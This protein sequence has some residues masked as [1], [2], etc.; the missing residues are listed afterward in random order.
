MRRQIA[1]VPF[2]VVDCAEP[3]TDIEVKIL[4]DRLGCGLDQWDRH[5]LDH[6]LTIA[7]VLQVSP[8]F[9]RKADDIR[10]RLVREIAAGGER[11]AIALDLDL[12]DDL[13]GYRKDVARMAVLREPL[14]DRPTASAVMRAAADLQRQMSDLADV[15]ERS[16]RYMAEV[17]AEDDAGVGRIVDPIRR[18]FLGELLDIAAEADASLILPSNADRE[19]DTPL[20]EFAEEMVALAEDRAR[21]MAAEDELWAPAHARVLRWQKAAR[22]TL[23]SDLRLICR[24]RQLSGAEDEDPSA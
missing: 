18:R 24:S 10:L 13:K 2:G 15:L 7:T 23:I 6:A 19:R 3:L 22:S 14:G 9:N 1:I 17:G 4:E 16:N 12:D 11:A 8:H 5:R 21:R 20:L